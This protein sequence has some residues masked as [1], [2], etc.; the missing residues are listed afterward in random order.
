MAEPQ[1]IAVQFSEAIEFLRRRL[2]LTSAE[3]RAIW[4]QAG[5]VAAAAASRETSQMHRDVL[6]LVLKAVEDGTTL[7]QFREAYAQLVAEHETESSLFTGNLGQRA[8]LVF[9]LHT[10]EA[11]AAGRW[12]QAERIAELN[13]QNQYYW[14]YITVGDHRVR[15]QHKEWAGIILPKDHWFWRTHFPPNGFNCRCHVQ[16]VTERDMRRRGW[17]VTL[18]TDPRLGTPPDPGFEGNVGLAGARLAKLQRLP[19]VAPA[20]SS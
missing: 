2:N 1:A 15:P 4:Q 6:K 8:Q 18:E 14:R 17:T 9:R 16:L 5:G 20:I 3:W 19:A 12:E 7:E 10:M 13:P 11:Y